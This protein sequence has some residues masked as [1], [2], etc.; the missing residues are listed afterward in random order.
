MKFQEH[1]TFTIEKRSGYLY[2]N[3]K[4]PF[5]GELVQT[6]ALE[7]KNALEVMAGDP[8]KQLVVVH[9]LALMIP[10]AKDNLVKSLQYRKQTGLMRAAM[11][12]GGVEAHSLVK[13]Q[14]GQ[15]YQLADIEHAFFDHEDTAIEW[16]NVVSTNHNPHPKINI[17]GNEDIDA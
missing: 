4:G 3:A 1:G 16:L 11:V 12:I 14:F 5:N 15:C 6:Y 9:G 7:L 8:W 2:I 17:N 13:A 10:V